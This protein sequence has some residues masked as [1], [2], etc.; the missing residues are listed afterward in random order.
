M[1]DPTSIAIAGIVAGTAG[2][3]YN[4][5][6]QNAFQRQVQAEQNRQAIRARE[7]REEERLRQQALDEE[8]YATV[9]DNYEQLAPD[10]R[11]AEIEAAVAAGD[12]P[13]QEAGRRYQ[14]LPRPQSVNG[15]VLGDAGRL[16]DEAA[17]QR[18]RIEAM[19]FL[20][21]QNS[22]EQAVRDR[23]SRTDST[24]ANNNSEG[25][26]SLSLSNFEQNIPAANVTPSNSIFG[27]LLVGA[28]QLG[29]AYA[30]RMPTGYTPTGGTPPFIDW[31]RA[32]PQ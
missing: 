20:A 27:D 21:A 16:A 26:R 24:L 1:C 22:D 5:V 9:R 32:R 6:Q 4:A 17:R 18:A 25:R 30:G 10:Q 23:F 3:A 19:A 8:N 7:A 29:G 13:V 11:A 28:G 15:E 31:S 12:T 2:T 14:P